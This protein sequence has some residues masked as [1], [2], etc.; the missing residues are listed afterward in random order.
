M[1][2]VNF[3]IRTLLK[4]IEYHSVEPIGTR[5]IIKYRDP[6]KCCREGILNIDKMIDLS[7]I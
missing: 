7:L 1:P 6:L 2:D 4:S 3:T 5:G